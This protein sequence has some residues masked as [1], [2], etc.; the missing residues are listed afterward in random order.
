MPPHSKSLAEEGA[1]F[2]SFLLVDGGVFNEKGIIERLTTPTNAPGAK[3]TRNLS[4]NLSDLKAQIAANQKGIQL[5]VELIDAY[6]L[7]YVQAYMNYIQDSAESFVRDMLKEI[8]KETYL[9]TKTTSLFA[10]EKMDDGTSICLN[11]TIDGE[12]G[13]AIFDFTGTGYEVL[14]PTFAFSSLLQSISP[15]TNIFPLLKINSPHLFY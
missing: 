6:G 9:R 4:D 15:F 3:G 13:N 12:K 11:V 2:K 1:A 10:E 8:A 7:K 5:V 14:L